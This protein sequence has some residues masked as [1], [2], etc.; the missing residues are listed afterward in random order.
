MKYDMA[1]DLDSRNSLSLM[2]GQ[3]KNN[4]VVLEFGPANGR[5]TKYLKEQLNCKVYIVEYDEEAAKDAMQYAEDGIVGDIMQ[6]EWLDRWKAVSFDYILFADVLEHL[7]NPQMVLN[8]T[9][10]ILKDDGKVILSVPNVGH[11]SIMINLYNNIFNYAPLGLLDDTHIHLFAYNTLVNFCK[12]AGYCPIIKDATYV[13]VGKTEIDNTFACVPKDV[14]MVLKRREYGN[15]YQYVFVLQKQEFVDTHGVICDY[16]I[17]THIPDSI[18][19]I[20]IDRGNGWQ[21]DNCIIC[22]YDSKNKQ[23]F[24]FDLVNCQEIKGLRIDPAEAAGVLEINFELVIDGKHKMISLDECWFNGKKIDGYLMFEND[25][26]QIVFDH[27]TFTEKKQ[28]KLHVVFTNN[29]LD[30][31]TILDKIIKDYE[32]CIQE[33]NSYQCTVVKLKDELQKKEAILDEQRE[34]ISELEKKKTIKKM[35]E[36]KKS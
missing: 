14:A 27:I 23:D 10:R 11:N 7:S 5:L 25:D 12:E 31:R 26:P 28:V 34:K 24:T 30:N 13:E 19:K 9:R 15:V 3:I 4:S 6:L 1:L 21:E 17:L 22:S 20:Y 16:R 33:K 29:N 36:I 18:L 32:Q 2:I 8:H 35:F